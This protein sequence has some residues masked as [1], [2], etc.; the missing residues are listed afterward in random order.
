MLQGYLEL[1]QNANEFESFLTF[2][3]NTPHPQHLHKRQP[4]SLKADKEIQLILMRFYFSSRAG[5]F[6]TSYGPGK[7]FEILDKLLNDGINVPYKYYQHSIT[8]LAH[9]NNNS[10]TLTSMTHLIEIMTRRSGYSIT[11]DHGII[12]SLI[13]AMSKD[14]NNNDAMVVIED[15]LDRVTQILSQLVDTS[16]KC[17][18][19][20]GGIQH[21][22]AV[23]LLVKIFL[24]KYP[25]LRNGFLRR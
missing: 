25:F 10:D 3:E 11:R 13:Y 21:I 15:Y 23:L 4:I 9:N 24:E 18:V 17:T 14:L 6:G 2:L 8:Q 12:G 19:S 20:F 7:A 22:D 16:N 5:K 1:C